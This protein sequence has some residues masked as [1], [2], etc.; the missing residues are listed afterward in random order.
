ML[1]YYTFGNHIYSLSLMNTYVF[2]VCKTY[3]ASCICTY[4]L[5]TA[6][7]CIMLMNCYVNSLKYFTFVT[8]ICFFSSMIPLVFHVCWS[9]LFVCLFFGNF[10]EVFTAIHKHFTWQPN[11]FFH[12]WLIVHS[13]FHWHI[14]FSLFML[15][16]FKIVH[17]CV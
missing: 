2:F 12:I 3:F 4:N 11:L 16:S 8:H 1:K 14:S 5:N 9:Y 17:A 6:N 13:L 15:I 10:Y 7:M